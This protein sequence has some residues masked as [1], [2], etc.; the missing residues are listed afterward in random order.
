MEVRTRIL[1]LS[2]PAILLVLLIVAAFFVHF[3]TSTTTAPPALVSRETPQPSKSPPGNPPAE[4][5]TTSTPAV[6][7]Q[8]PEP[9]LATPP[10]QAP[11]RP[12]TPEVEILIRITG[13]DGAPLP[14]CE[15]EVFATNNRWSEIRRSRHQANERGEFRYASRPF[16]RIAVTA[17]PEGFLRGFYLQDLGDGS[18]TDLNAFKDHVLPLRKGG[19]LFEGVAADDRG[20]AMR[21][22]KLRFCPQYFY[23]TELSHAPRPTYLP[24]GDANPEARFFLEDAEV[25]TDEYGRFKATGLR[26]TE[27]Y[28]VGLVR[29]GKVESSVPLGRLSNANPTLMFPR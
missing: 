28:V 5:V 2:W 6:P 27:T 14:F 4:S 21:S 11:G 16:A 22:Q 13:D 29:D 17:H 24:P 23:R 8:S 9:A 1:Q 7:A 25:I 3:K 10:S 15:A 26:A 20:I 12:P 19:H 18:Q